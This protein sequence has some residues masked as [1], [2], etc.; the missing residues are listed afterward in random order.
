MFLSLQM[1]RTLSPGSRAIIDLRRLVI[2]VIADAFV[3][4]NPNRTLVRKLSHV[5]TLVLTTRG[6]HFVRRHRGVSR[7][8]LRKAQEA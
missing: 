3:D 2:D 1:A 5:P 6:G 8:I 7:N 4:A